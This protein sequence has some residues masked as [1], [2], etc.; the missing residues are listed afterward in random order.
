MIGAQGIYGKRV[1]YEGSLGVPLVMAGPGIRQG[2]VSRQLVSHVDLFPTFVEA[3]GARLE[4]GD[5]DLPGTSLWPALRGQDDL[6]RPLFAEFH[7]QGS[8][9]GTF[10]IRQHDLKLIHHVGMPQ[11]IFDLASDPYELNDLAGTPAGTAISAKLTP[12]LRSVCNI[13][14][15]SARAKADQRAKAESY[16]GKDAVGLA[17]YI[18][19]TPPPGVSAEQAWSGIRSNT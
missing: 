17:E 4:E 18:V 6:D 8:K 11:Q 13:D 2:H 5:D 1:V 15:V 9:T 12:M 16:G 7:G 3:V 19:F 14:V 10:V